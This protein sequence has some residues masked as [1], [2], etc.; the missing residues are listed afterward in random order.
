MDF[1]NNRNVA[2]PGQ[3]DV[4]Q[5]D[6]SFVINT[7]NWI[8]GEIVRLEDGSD[9]VSAQND[10][11]KIIERKIPVIEE[12]GGNLKVL[13]PN[14]NTREKIL[15]CLYQKYPQPLNDVYLIQN[16]KYNNSSR[17]KTYL[18]LL[19]VKESLVDYSKGVVIL[20]KRGVAWVEKNISFEVSV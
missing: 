3:I 20:T 11:N 13:N 7:A 16:I 12:I 14:L 9:P 19:Y 10:I 15:L 18:K 17:F 2:H 1:R 8:M 4:N 6:A 5:L